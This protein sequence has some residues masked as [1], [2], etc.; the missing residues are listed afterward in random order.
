LVEDRSTNPLEHIGHIS[1]YPNVALNTLNRDQTLNR[2]NGLPASQRGIHEEISA[3]NNFNAYNG[4]SIAAEFDH[5][6]DTGTQELDC[7]VK[8]FYNTQ[9]FY[10]QSLNTVENVME[11]CNDNLKG[12][13]KTEFIVPYDEDE[14]IRLSDHGSDRDSESGMSQFCYFCITN[15]ASPDSHS[16][17]F[18][19]IVCIVL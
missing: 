17:N 15:L 13:A 6:L 19:Q 14:G 1:E 9:Q 12:P 11:F 4:S 16:S 10:A 5:R 2:L 3:A 7:D 18:T 8:S